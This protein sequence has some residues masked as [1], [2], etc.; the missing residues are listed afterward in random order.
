MKININ[1]S[2]V[3]QFEVIKNNFDYNYFLKHK[4]KLNNFLKKNTN[5]FLNIEKILGYKFV[6]K[7]IEAYLFCSNHK[8]ISRPFLL[9][10][11]TQNFNYIIF[12]FMSLL[13]HRIFFGNDLYKNFKTLEKIEVINFY[14]TKLIFKKYFSEKEFDKILNEYNKY[15]FKQYVL[16]DV[17]ILEK[18]I[19]NKNLRKF[20]K[21]I[22][23]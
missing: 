15:L 6:E 18:K 7:E 8:S 3:L 16:D 14:F 11:N 13:I 12:D 5:L 21:N 23:F 9:N 4:K 20:L 22:C 19:K 10:I 2:F 17:K 1:I